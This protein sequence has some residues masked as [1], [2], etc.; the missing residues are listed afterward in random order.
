MKIKYCPTHYPIHSI[1]LC[2]DIEM[3]ARV[4][5]SET[6][7]F[8]WET[9]GWFTWLPR[10]LSISGEIIVPVDDCWIVTLRRVHVA[11]PALDDFWQITMQNR[12]GISIQE[13]SKLHRTVN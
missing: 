4:Q 13:Q 2:L 11:H 10:A 1:G 9:M 12:K 3:S 8:V 7:D 6:M 5:F